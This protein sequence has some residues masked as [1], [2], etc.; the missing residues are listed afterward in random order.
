M[1]ILTPRKIGCCFG[2]NRAVK[3]TE[4]ALSRGVPAYINGELV[5]N[6]TITRKLSERGLTEIKSIDE[7]KDGTLIIRAHGISPAERAKVDAKRIEIVDATCPIVRQAQVAAK[8]IEEEGYQVVIVG[9]KSHAEIKGIL[10]HL[11]NEALVVSSPRE[12]DPSKLRNKVGLI[13]QTT[14][15]IELCREVVAE[16]MKVSHEIKIVNTICADIRKRQED[17]VKLAQKTGLMIVVGSHHSSNTIKLKKLCQKYNDNTIQIERAKDLDP[18]RFK[19]IK[20]VGIIG[21][22]STPDILIEEVKKRLK[23]ISKK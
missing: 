16:V 6:D 8:K 10:G 21:G 3:L 14:H 15:S 20:S 12:I 1:K 5:H 9:D 13:F 23:S 4:E 18:K 11:K 19:G 17:A 22:A 2:V 7:V